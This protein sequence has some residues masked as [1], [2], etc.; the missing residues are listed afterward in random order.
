MEFLQKAESFFIQ[1]QY[2]LAIDPEPTFGG[3]NKIYLLML[4]QGLFNELTSQFYID[5]P[6]FSANKII[7]LKALRIKENISS[8]DALSV[9]ESLKKKYWFL[10][11]V[12]VFKPVNDLLTKALREEDCNISDKQI[13]VELQNFANYFHETREKMYLDLLNAM[14]GGLDQAPKANLLLAPES[15]QN[16]F[17]DNSPTEIYNHFK[18][19]LVDKGYLT[20]QELNDYLRLA[21]ELKEK[22][23]V[24][25][26]LKH[27]PTKQKI[28]TIFYEYYKVI[29]Q[30]KHNRQKEYV[31]L[32][33]DY[34][35]GYTNSV[36]S[37][38]WAKGYKAKR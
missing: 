25:F 3:K 14:Q 6:F 36:I 21:F 27:T 23:M 9:I 37:S 28:Y 15:F 1:L 5:Y 16:N 11:M 26:K 19:G 18:S 24:L 38:N 30:K 29:S 32:L 22:P 35:K 20:E 17:D 12:T 33:G 7:E 34:F 8:E 4:E 13:H 2:C 31:A 10:D